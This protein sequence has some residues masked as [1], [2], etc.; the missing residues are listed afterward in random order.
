MNDKKYVIAE[1]GS[2]HCCKI[3]LAIKHIEEAAKIGAQAVKF[4]LLDINKQYH[5]PNPELI[6][7]HKKADFSVDNL[8]ILKKA[9]TLNKIDF[10]CSGTFLEA[11]DLIDSMEPSF[12]KI[13]SAQVPHFP[14]YLEKINSKNRLTLA[15]TGIAS[16]GDI[17][18]LVDIFGGNGNKNLILM[19]CKSRYP[20]DFEKSELSSIKFLQDR[21]SLEVALSDHTL[22]NEAALVSLGMGV[23]IFEKHFK[24]DNSI[25]SPD[26]SSS[27]DSKS[28]KDYIDTINRTLLSINS[29]KKYR[30]LDKSENSLKSQWEV[31]VLA[32]KSI[33]KGQIINDSDLSYKRANQGILASE[34][35]FIMKD[36]SI[37]ATKDIKKNEIIQKS[38]FLKTE[39]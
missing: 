18:K 38:D 3:D 5:S 6:E 1:I 35:Y 15:S 34:L 19:H 24:L 17:D 27:I 20:L 21:Y 12:H 23:R 4:Q 11:A 7:L 25:N 39:K 22:T 32:S 26:S 33:K 31:N 30:S 37:R 10:M 9:T 36:N 13:A 28:M 2:N 8:L 16:L 14:Q 29:S